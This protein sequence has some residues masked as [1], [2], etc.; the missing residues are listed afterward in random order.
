MADVL[1]VARIAPEFLQAASLSLV[2]TSPI[3]RE[4]QRKTLFNAPLPIDWLE[5]F[6]QTPA[7]PAFILANEFL[8]RCLFV[9]ISKQL[10]VG[11]NVSL[12]L[13]QRVH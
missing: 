3:L 8:M 12:D 10:Q 11:G 6:S 7:G 1:R 4:L 2:E 13:M 5:Q 9:T